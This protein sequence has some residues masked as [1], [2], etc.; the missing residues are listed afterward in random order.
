MAKAVI[1]F[2]FLN[3]DRRSADGPLIA[4]SPLLSVKCQL[5][6]P[7]KDQPQSLLIKTHTH[8]GDRDSSLCSQ[9][10]TENTFPR[11]ERIFAQ[12]NSAQSSPIHTVTVT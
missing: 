2:P 10:S 5:T 4:Y 6:F 7:Q 12:R 1:F 8:H 11:L 9:I 3:S